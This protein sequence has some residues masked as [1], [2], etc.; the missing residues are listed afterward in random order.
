MMIA[1]FVFIRLLCKMEK[2]EIW[3]LSKDQCDQKNVS[4][5][6]KAVKKCGK[7]LK[8]DN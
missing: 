4:Q 2:T 5:M 7:I 3:G 1:F 6:A 8:S